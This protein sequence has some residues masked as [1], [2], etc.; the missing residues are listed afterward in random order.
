MTSRY[1]LAA[2][3]LMTAL[4]IVPLPSRAK[5]DKA[6]EKPASAEKPAEPAP[7]ADVTTQIGRA[8]V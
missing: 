3:L 4:L 6:V 8:H 7:H 1:R 5:D 2:G